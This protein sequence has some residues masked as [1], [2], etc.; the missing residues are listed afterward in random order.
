MRKLGLCLHFQVESYC[1]NYWDFIIRSNFSDAS[2]HDHFSG[3]RFCFDLRTPAPL[4]RS[5]GL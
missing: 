1:K 4:P 2:Q 5:V 3:C